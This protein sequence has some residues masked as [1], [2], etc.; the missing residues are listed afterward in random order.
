[1]H[2]LRHTQ[3]DLVE[4]HLRPVSPTETKV[5]FQGPINEES[6]HKLRVLAE[7]LKPFQKITF[8][9]EGI[10]SVDSLGVR[11]WVQFLRSL[12]TSGRQIHFSRCNADVVSQINMIPS[13]AEGAVI[14]S[15]LVNYICPS[16]EKSAKAVVETGKVPKGTHP[17]APQCPHC[18]KAAMETE[19][20]EDEYFAFLDRRL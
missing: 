16:C 4:I 8:D 11:S 12:R 9:F 7:Q 20:L 15:F 2:H 3:G 17:S 10:A 14:D 19:E 6:D 13:F 1:M 18:R 5:A